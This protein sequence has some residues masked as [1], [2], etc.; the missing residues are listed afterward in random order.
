VTSTPPITLQVEDSITPVSCNG[1]PKPT[2]QRP[3]LRAPFHGWTSLVSYFD[4]DLPN[5]AQD[6]ELVTTTG[7]RVVPDGRH[8]VSDFPAY[9]SKGLR[10]YVYYDGHNGYDFDLSYRPVYAAAPGKVIFAA[11]EYPE[12][13]HHGYGR[14]VMVAHHAGYITLYGHFSKLL[15]KKGQRVKAGQELGISGNTGH[16]SG[17]HLHFTLFHN[18]TPTDPYGWSGNGPD[19]LQNYQGES[20]V[21]LW[22]KVPLL[23]NPP[24]EWP[25]ETS[26]I[27]NSLPRLVLVRLPSTTRGTLDFTTALITELDRTRRALGAAATHATIDPLR[28]AI[29]IRAP[30]SA[31]RLYAIPDVASIGSLDASDGAVRDVLD[32]LAQ[33]ALYTSSRRLPLDASKK[34]NGFLFAWDGRSFLL[35]RGVPGRRAV[36]TL[37][38]ANRIMH[39]QVTT[40]PKSGA[41]A[42]DLGRLSGADRRA[43]VRALEPKIGRIGRATTLKYRRETGSLARR[44]MAR[45]AQNSWTYPAALVL[46]ALV[47][48]MALGIRRGVWHKKPPA[49]V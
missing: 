6:G 15:V 9:W 13:P 41:Y 34:W 49:Q 30:I 39:R 20:S 2:A 27:V 48:V 23:D 16:S 40:D 18:C 8:L 36:L 33:A 21:Y 47:L 10:Q 25:G 19:P 35:G 11:F 24:P 42:L 4:H 46:V 1:P 5:F 3:F 7:L 37:A 45:T 17:P 14:M 43:L 32:S 12:M 38:A 44:P 26:Q 31:A 22:Q 29:I 28:G